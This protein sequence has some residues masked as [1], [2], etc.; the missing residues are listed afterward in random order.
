MNDEFA[1][2]VESSRSTFASTFTALF[3]TAP[4]A[5][6]STTATAALADG[7]RRELAVTG[8]I[9]YLFGRPGGFEPY[10]G[11][12][13][14]VITGAGDGATAT[15]EGGY[16]FTL[17]GGAP[18]QRNGSGDAAVDQPHR[19]R[20]RAGRR[21]PSR[22]V[23]TLGTAD[24]RTRLLGPATTR[25][26]LDAAPVGDCATP[27]GFIESFTYPSVQ[28]SN[29]GSTG[30]RSTLGGAALQGFEPLHGQRSRDARRSITGGV[31][32]ALLSRSA[33]VPAA[34]R[35]REKMPSPCV[36]AT[37]SRRSGTISRSTISAS[38]NPTPASAP[39]VAPWR[40]TI[41][42][43]SVAGVEIAAHVVEGDRVDRE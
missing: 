3:S 10:V 43:K 16:R 28:F 37:S 24:R 5:G 31:F 11:F 34:G 8:T 27:A 20:G 33:A 36:A 41:G 6:V 38:G 21:T 42:P 25:V 22:S 7:S 35:L 9:H 1:A 4:L 13:G 15:V 14:G 40:S 17:P 19:T 32:R 23:R 26:T 2:A 39:R 12:G 29:D 30:R 18:H